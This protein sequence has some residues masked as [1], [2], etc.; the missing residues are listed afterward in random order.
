MSEGEFWS[1]TLAQF[2]SLAKRY[3]FEQETLDYRGALIC[4]IIAEVNR[5]KKKRSRP[6]TPKDFMLKKKVKLTVEQMKNQIEAI[7]IALGGE[8]S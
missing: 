1:L 3:A 8:V 7:N 4:S 2:N 6:F 5:D